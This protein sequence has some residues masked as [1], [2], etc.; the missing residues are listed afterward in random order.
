MLYTGASMKNPASG[1]PKRR[2]LLGSRARTKSRAKKTLAPPA[3]PPVKITSVA[4]PSPSVL[5]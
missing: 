1:A 2:V 5:R 4:A 3:L